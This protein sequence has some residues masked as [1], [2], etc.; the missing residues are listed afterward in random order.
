MTLASGKVP[1][2]FMTL[3]SGR[4]GTDGT[5]ALMRKIATGRYGS[6][7][8]KIRALAINILRQ[9]GVPEKDYRAET[10]ALHNWVRDNIRYTMDVAGQETLSHPEEVAFNTKAGD[11]LSGD[12]RLLT[13]TGYVCIR[14]VR[15][16]ETVQGRNGWTRVTNWWDKGVLP[17][18][19][20][21][22]ASGGCFT[23]TDDHKCFLLDGTEVRA[24]DL[25]IDSP[26]L[27]P[28]QIT[29]DNPSELLDADYLFL[30]I[31]LADGWEDGNRFCISGKDGFAKEAQK[32]WVKDYAESKG[33]FTSW[34]P[35]YIRVYVPE[36]HPMYTILSGLGVAEQKAVPSAAWVQL[37]ASRAAHLLEGLLVDSHHP[38]ETQRDLDAVS[39]RKSTRRSGRCFSTTSYELAQ[40]VRILYRL[41]G[42]G[43]RITKVV[44]HGGLGDNPVYRLYPRHFR[45][46]PAYVEH[47]ED[48][49][50][51]HV[52]DIET[53][54]H[55]I[56][57][58]DA[59]VV[60]HN[61]DD[62]A[63]LLAA[64]LGSVGIITRFKVLGVTKDRFSH[65]YLQ[66]QVAGQWM[67]LD[68]IM[69]QHPAGWE[70]PAH[71]RKIEK[72]YPDNIP[73]GMAMPR[74]VNGL[75]FVG[76]PRIVSHLEQEPTGARRANTPYVS[77][78]SFLDNDAPIEQLSNNSPAF[79]Q[80]QN[81]GPRMPVP[82]MKRMRANLYDMRNRLASNSVQT[83][84]QL[85]DEHVDAAMSP[86]YGMNDVMLPD[87]LA[88]MGIGEMDQQP[89]EYMQRPAI[90]VEPQGIDVQ[91]GRNA[92]V[93]R[94][95]RG[96]RMLYRGLWAMNEQPPIRRIGLGELPGARGHLGRRRMSGPGLADL[97]DAT[98]AAA[99]PNMSTS[100]APA[101]GGALIGLVL[102]AAGAYLFCRKAR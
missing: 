26:L 19:R 97:A 91:F 32:R 17:V 61:C 89:Q 31:Y 35:R 37:N 80:D 29:I 58:P 7:S 72:V 78:N 46:K 99:D 59:D 50:P 100:A 18:R 2:H 53:E 64:L 8:P 48:V 9:A 47:I 51:E 81:I 96:D 14:D 102:L 94:S 6:R 20:Y 66:A 73:E 38:Q 1:V 82:H 11:C 79:P 95:D 43:C 5:V 24:G 45:P 28:A 21:H 39:T 87:E 33:W 36:T 15:P 60:V 70:A 77:M 23:A 86:G 25:E 85:M 56:Y 63:A 22:L 49:A 41:Q 55:G 101:R 93:M 34:H 10:V 88:G 3:P 74:G 67:T 98:D 75:G 52:F 4:A 57:L 44:D 71:M 92:L 65:V 90:A 83:D 30:G 84:E 69:R 16:G 40:Q 62:K 12:T 54:D 42:V 27:G 76:D 13:P 68:P